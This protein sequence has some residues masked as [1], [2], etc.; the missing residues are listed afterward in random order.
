MKQYVREWRINKV[1][2]SNYSD[3]MFRPNGVISHEVIQGH[4]RVGPSTLLVW[5]LHIGYPQSTLK[6]GNTILVQDFTVNVELVQLP[7]GP[8]SSLNKDWVKF[9]RH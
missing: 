3:L 1:L 4:A 2:T 9:L 6:Q 5:F 8:D 7:S